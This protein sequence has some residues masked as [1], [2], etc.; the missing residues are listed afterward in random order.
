TAAYMSPEQAQGGESDHRSDIFSFGVVLY[1]LITGEIPFKGEHEAALLYEVVNTPAKPL[2]EVRSDV[3]DELERI[4]GKGMEK[5]AGD[6][7]QHVD[8]MLIDLKRLKKELETEEILKKTGVRAVVQKKK[9]RWLVP[10]SVVAGIAALVIGYIVFQPKAES[11]ERIPVAVVDFVNETK[12]EEL[13]GLSGLLITS[14]EQS[15]RLSVVTRSRMFDILK[16]LGK[17]DVERIDETLGREICKQ[18][19]VNALLMASVRKFGQR[20]TIDLKVLDP[21]KDEYLF[22]AREEGEGQENIPSMIDKL[23]QK[24]RV[25]LKEKAAEIHAASR[26][27]AEVATPNLEAYQHYFK[28]EELVGKLKWEEAKAEFNQAIALDTTFALAYYRLAYAMGWNSEEGAKEPIRK[29]MEYIEKVPEKERYLIRAQYASIEGNI[30]EAIAIYQE[31]LKLYPEEKEALYDIGDQSFHQGNYGTAVSYLEKVLAID[32]TFARALGHIIWTYRNMGQYD[33]MLE[34][35]EEYVAKAPSENAYFWLGQAYNLRAEFNEAFQTYGQA[36][37][38]FP[39]STMPVVGMGVIY[40]FKDDYE[41]AEVEFRKLLQ[42]PRPLSDTRDG[43]A[44]LTKLYAYLGKYRETVK[45]VDKIIEID[46]KLADN[47]DLAGTYAWKAFWLVV[48]RNGREQAE[49]AIEKGLELKKYADVSFY[50][51]LFGTYLM[52]SEYEKASS[53]VKSQLSRTRPFLDVLVR[54]HVHQAKGEYEDAIRDFQMYIQRLGPGAKMRSGYN[55]AQCYFESGQNERAIEA[56]QTAQRI[57]MHTFGAPWRAA[58]YPRG[59]YL[60]GKIYEKKG[61]ERLAIENYEKF[62]DLWKDADGDLPDLIDVKARL[63]KL[64]GVA[65]R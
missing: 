38:L 16:Q 9:L 48:G 52:M 33:K 64:K 53:I 25:G 27:V 19:N 45:L 2:K 60:L 4:V 49:K 30:D 43:Y 1:E 6:R 3:P 51:P 13:D 56:I 46:L 11:G 40:I 54:A 50:R 24:T 14:L 10:A 28:G 20:Y 31:L 62:L 65:T 47:T 23:A 59:F 57:F 22:T 63:A 41:K 5:N 18:A 44:N 37:E 61:D 32:P 42:K 21:Q 58:F 8:E 7:Y 26:K 15:R 12:E 36:L 55:L 34:Y 39:T 17:G 29:A 35:A